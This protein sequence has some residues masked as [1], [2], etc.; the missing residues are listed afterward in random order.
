M[1]I[2]EKIQSELRHPFGCLLALFMGALGERAALYLLVNAFP[3]GEEPYDVDRLLGGMIVGVFVVVV[4][5]MGFDREDHHTQGCYITAMT[6]AITP[7]SPV[8][9][10][11]DNA[12]FAWNVHQGV[13]IGLH[14][15]VILAFLWREILRNKAVD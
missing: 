10:D 11:A 13:S 7:V 3:G 2:W 15:A 4:Y 14:V 8:C 6:L 5:A 1:N 9:L 12:T